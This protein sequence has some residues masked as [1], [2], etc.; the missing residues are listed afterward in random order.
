VVYRT[1]TDK[2][3]QATASPKFRAWSAAAGLWCA[4]P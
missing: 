2:L 3:E 1:A 4:R